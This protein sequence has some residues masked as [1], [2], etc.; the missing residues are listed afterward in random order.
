MDTFIYKYIATSSV[1][2]TA[3]RVFSSIGLGN[4]HL[5]FRLS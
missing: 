4:F 3:R 1:F 5:N 2:D